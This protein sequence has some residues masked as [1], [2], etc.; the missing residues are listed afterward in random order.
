LA[1]GEWPPSAFHSRLL[2]PPQGAI[3][4]TGRKLQSKYKHLVVRC[5]KNIALHKNV[6]T[7]ACNCHR[8]TGEIV[9]TTASASPWGGTGL[10]QKGS[11]R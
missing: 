5:N 2:T 9:A 8:G 1:L 10:N 4:C 6:T 7:L 3:K 11:K